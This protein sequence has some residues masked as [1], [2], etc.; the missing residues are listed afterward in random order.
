M[1][2]AGCS[3][4]G[5]VILVMIMQGSNGSVAVSNLINPQDLAP[6]FAGTVFGIMQTFATFAGAIVPKV[7]SA[8]LDY[9][10]W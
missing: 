9:Y 2:A 1:P 5:I 6:N 7:T 4:A 8:F 10:V 3:A